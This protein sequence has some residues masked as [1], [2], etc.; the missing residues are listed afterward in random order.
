MLTLVL[1]V[2]GPLACAG[3]D[4]RRPPCRGRRSGAGPR[5]PVT[6]ADPGAVARSTVARPARRRRAVDARAGGRALGDRRGCG[7]PAGGRV[8]ADS[9]DARRARGCAGRAGGAPGSLGHAVSGASPRSCP[10]RSSGWRPSCGVA[11]RWRRRSNGWPTAAERSVAI[12]TAC[13]C[14]PSSGCHSRT[15]SPGGRGARRARCP[16]RGRRARR[17]RRRWAGRPPTPSTGWPASLRSPARRD[18]RGPR[19]LG[20]GAA[21][22]ARR[23]RGPA[24]VPGVL[25]ARRPRGGDRAG[26]HRRRAGVPRA[27]PRPGGTRR[28]LDPSH[29]AARRGELAD[30]AVVA[31]RRSRGA[32]CWP[33]RSCGGHAGSAPA[34][35]IARAGAAVRPGAA[36][37]RVRG[38]DPGR[39]RP[40]ARGPSDVCSAPCTRAGGP[41]STTTPW[42]GSCRSSSISWASRSVPAAR[43]TS[44]SRSRPTGRRRSV[45]APLAGVLRSCAL[46]MGFAS[47]LDAAARATPAA[48]PARRRAARV[49]PARVPRW[50]RPSLVSPTRSGPR[51]GGGPRPTPV[52]S[53]SGCC[54]RSCSW[55]CPRSCCSRWSPGWRAASDGSDRGGGTG[56]AH[57]PCFPLSDHERR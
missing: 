17:W 16:S 57:F 3:L 56:R 51:C 18:G 14:A 31:A 38:G 34:A 19:A 25:S 35:R 41:G 52:A 4:R 37:S 20:P 5:H 44:R 6:L 13:T 29:P 22:G 49:R 47:A 12:S 53:R 28:A 55:C 46:G 33:C 42:R 15:R 43:R 39:R 30:G 45:A 10:P 11:A 9:R 8:R 24:R 26:R 2:V 36:P 23:R 50:R 27:R 1:A 7:R 32:R 21:V 48:P 54:S 40:V